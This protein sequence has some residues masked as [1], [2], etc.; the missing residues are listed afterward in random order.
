MST[1]ADKGRG[2]ASGRDLRGHDFAS[3]EARPHRLPPTRAGPDLLPDRTYT[4][5][6]FWRFAG[7]LD[8]SA[9]PRRILDLGPTSNANIQFWTQRGFD[10]SC[11]DLFARESL[12]LD[13]G[14]VTPMTLA[15]E[16]LR[17]RAFPYPSESFSALC[18]WNV[19]ARLPF[20]LAQRYV[21]E[22]YRVLHPS[23]LVHAV[24]LDSDGRPDS[25]RQYHVADRNQIAV[26]SRAVPRQ[27]TRC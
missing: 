15:G 7:A 26:S 16:N 11:Y 13:D 19:F 23:G 21:R 12:R 10:V 18:A 14:P 4:S 3:G 22:C 25:R 5:E 17:S 27:R 20:V 8:P 24:F 2:N 9:P 6:L 1:E